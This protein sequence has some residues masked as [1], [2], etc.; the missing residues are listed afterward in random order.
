M[1]SGLVLLLLL[2]LGAGVAAAGAAAAVFAVHPEAVANVVGRAEILAA[3]F[4][5]G[6]CLAYLRSTDGWRSAALVGSLY[7]LAMGSK[8][9]GVTLPAA[10]LLL[11]LHLRNMEDGAWIGAIGRGVREQW[12]VFALV[13]V[14][15]AL[16][17]ALRLA[18][19]GVAVGGDVAPWFW[20][21]PGATRIWT[22]IRLWP[23]YARLLFFPVRPS[24]DYGPD[25]IVPESTSTAPFVLLGFLTG[26]AASALAAFTWNR[27]RFVSLGLV[28]IALT[29]L[30]VSGLLFENSFLLAERTLYLP[31]VGIAIAGAGALEWL[32]GRRPAWL[33]PAFAAL[34]VW[35]AA[36]AGRTWI[37]NPVWRDDDTLFAYLVAN[38]PTNYRAHLEVY[39]QLRSLGREEEAFEHLT[40]A[41]ELVPGHYNVRMEAGRE[42][43]VR[44]RY[45][46][47]TEHFDVARRIAPGVE[48][49]HLLYLTSLIRAD[50][51][52]TAARV[53][54]EIVT[55]FPESAEARRLLTDLLTAAP[56][57][58]P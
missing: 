56:S 33:R 44:G 2:G 24:P 40:A 27:A 51:Y 43:F 7:F 16:H 9:S 13:A 8:E 45:A 54:A 53:G 5:L 48:L 41:V 49:P 12:R 17:L 52:E 11:L 23:E 30:P 46:E 34:F 21:E 58:A 57:P 47:A 10:L 14:A 37:Q 32:A 36:G 35:V 25:V 29:V 31:S 18:F 20:G 39:S 26:A 38:H 28:W 42:L 19:I 3:L 4:Y 55:L 1:T 22:A 50:R 6:G 15:L